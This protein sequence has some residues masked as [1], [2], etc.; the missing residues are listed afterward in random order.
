MLALHGIRARSPRR[1][2]A[3]VVS[4]SLPEPPGAVRETAKQDKRDRPIPP[5]SMAG[6]HRGDV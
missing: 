1:S 6:L 2:D 3:Q 4:V 5:D